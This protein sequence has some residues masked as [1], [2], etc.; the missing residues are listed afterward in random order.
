MFFYYPL[1]KYHCRRNTDAQQPT[2]KHGQ[3]PATLI[4]LAPAKPSLSHLHNCSTN[5]KKSK[6]KQITQRLEIKSKVSLNP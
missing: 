3:H 5:K 2:A 4:P 1:I 6:N